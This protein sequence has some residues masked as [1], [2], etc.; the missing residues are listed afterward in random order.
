[1]FSK[2]YDG[3]KADLMRL[4]VEASPTGTV[5]VDSDGCIILTNTSA[6]TLF[7]YTQKELLN[8]PIE[9]LVPARFINHHSVLRN[10]YFVKPET[11]AMGHG[12]DLYG[13]HKNGMEVPVEIGLNLIDFDGKKLILAAIV[14]IT[15]RKQREED[16]K[17]AL[18]EKEILLAEIHQRVKNNLQIIDSLLGIQSEKVTGDKA[19]AAFQERQNRVR[20]IATIHQILYEAQD[21]SK[22]EITGV[23]TSLVGNLVQSYGVDL[24]QIKMNLNLNLESFHLSID[25]RIPQSL[26]VNE[27]VTNA[28]KHASPYKRPGEVTISIQQS[29]SNDVTLIVEDTGIGIDESFNL[30]DSNSMGLQLVQTLVDQLRGTLTAQLS[31]PSRFR[32]VFPGS[33]DSFEP[34]PLPQRS[35]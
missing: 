19:R 21:I 4:A 16:L 27:L 33:N 22:V 24:D 14:D 25:K 26:I 17:S 12:R 35:Y 8:Q 6:E 2:R 9:I 30:E 34:Q 13:K 31:N 15:E 28:L 1:M 11:R 23:F 3:S 10:E 7:G 5:V 29:A 32:I 20:S 18:K